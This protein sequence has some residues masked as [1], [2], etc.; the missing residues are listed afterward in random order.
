MIVASPRPRIA[1]FRLPDLFDEE[2]NPTPPRRIEQN[3]HRLIGVFDHL[4]SNHGRAPEHHRHGS[5]RMGF[6]PA[7]V[8]IAS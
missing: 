4:R 7:R 1:L 5:R 2:H 3:R 8:A 6:L